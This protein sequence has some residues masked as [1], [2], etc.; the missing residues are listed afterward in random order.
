MDWPATIDRW[1]VIPRALMVTYM[2]LLNEATQWF[3]ALPDPNGAQSAF[4]AAVW[5]AGAVWFGAYV[6]SGG[7]HERP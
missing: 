6:N 7:K 1:R 4:I 2:W 5:G 3:M